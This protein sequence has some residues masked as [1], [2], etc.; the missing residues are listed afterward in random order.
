MLVIDAAVVMCTDCLPVK[1]RMPS[2]RTVPPMTV[3]VQAGPR[4]APAAYFSKS[5]QKRAPAAHAAAG[6]P[7]P[8]PS[9]GAGPSLDGAPPEPAGVVSTPASPGAGAPA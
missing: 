5:S 1:A 4:S 2:T 6:G 3:V 7:S 9:E 8:P